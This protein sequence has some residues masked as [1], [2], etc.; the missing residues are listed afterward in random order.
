MQSMVA[1]LGGDVAVCFGQSGTILLD[2]IN[3]IRQVH[4]FTGLKLH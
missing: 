2:M 3:F 4:T 1:A